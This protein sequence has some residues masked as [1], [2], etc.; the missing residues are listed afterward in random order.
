MRNGRYIIAR[1]LDTEKSKIWR[2]P[3]AGGTPLMLDLSVPNLVEF[4]LNPYNH[5]FAF[6][7]EEGPM[8]ELWVIENLVMITCIKE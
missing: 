7:T 5:S 1:A 8:I 6:T 4:T 3:T 2:I